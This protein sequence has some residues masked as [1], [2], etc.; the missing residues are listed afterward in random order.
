MLYCLSRKCAPRRT[1]TYTD[2]RAH[3]PGYRRAK[4]FVSQAADP[5]RIGKIQTPDFFNPFART[6][7]NISMT[8]TY[9][10][11]APAPERDYNLNRH[12]AAL[13]GGVGHVSHDA[14]GQ[15]PHSAAAEMKTK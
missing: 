15:V 11:R 3:L 12:L 10:A 14:D 8:L 2:I 4:H 6:S 1:K 7:T 9:A 5:P 13:L